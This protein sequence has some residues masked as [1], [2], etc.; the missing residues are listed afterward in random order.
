MVH[1]SLVDWS[2]SG[3]IWAW[4]TCEF[5]ACHWDTDSLRSNL[6]H[7]VRASVAEIVDAPPDFNGFNPTWLCR[8]V[9]ITAVS[10]LKLRGFR[11]D[12][13]E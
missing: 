6:E 1:V 10:D 2:S 4:V 9:L 5:L 7:K 11:R 12:L 3:C 8:A 13:M